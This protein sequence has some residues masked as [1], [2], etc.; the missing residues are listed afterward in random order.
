MMASAADEGDGGSQGHGGQQDGL[1]AAI[2][3]IQAHQ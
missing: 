3:L 1:K 2:G